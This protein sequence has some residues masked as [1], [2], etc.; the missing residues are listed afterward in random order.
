MYSTG[1]N[2]KL[3]RDFQ[4]LPP[5]LLAI[6]TITLFSLNFLFSSNQ[7]GLSSKYLSLY[8]STLHNQRVTSREHF[9]FN[10]DDKF[11]LLS[12]SILLR[13]RV[14]W[15]YKRIMHA[16]TPHKEKTSVLYSFSLCLSF[17]LFIDS[18]DVGHQKYARH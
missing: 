14:Y 16:H 2:N 1:M 12:S 17:Y 8:G 10:L 3:Y 6:I 4:T 9:V 5:F 7:T 11:P 15:D 18:V 13:L